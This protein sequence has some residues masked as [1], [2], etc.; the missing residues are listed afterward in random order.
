MSQGRNGTLMSSATC[1]MN[2]RSSPMKSIFLCPFTLVIAVAAGCSASTPKTP[3]TVSPTQPG[4]PVSTDTSH[5]PSVEKV[6]SSQ[7]P[8]PAATTPATSKEHTFACGDGR[9]KA[10][11]RCCPGAT[12]LCAKDDSCGEG[13]ETDVGFLCDTESNEPCPSGKKCVFDR[14]GFAGPRGMT[15]ECH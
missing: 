1:N 10:G 2:A 6:E 3:D 8:S 13:S 11:E 5:P 14:G 12:Q 15:A 7:K 9:C 4:V